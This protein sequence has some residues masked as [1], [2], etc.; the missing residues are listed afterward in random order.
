MYTSVA[1]RSANAYKRVAVDTALDAASPHQLVVMLF[2]ELLRSLESAR[3]AI[4]RGD[5]PDKVKHIGK[6]LRIVEEGLRAPLNLE[7]GGELAAN[8]H[9]LY[10]YCSHK[11]VLANVRSDAAALQEVASLIARIAESW[12]QIEG[13]SHVSS[14]S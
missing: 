9:A 3:R 4:A 1:A 14:A 13:A 11:L 7:A 2:D 6:A 8:L 10:E 12:K 5:V